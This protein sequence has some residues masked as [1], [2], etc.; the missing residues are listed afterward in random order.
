MV[1]SGSG[2]TKI[3]AGA[4]DALWHPLASVTITVKVSEEVTVMPGVFSPSDHKYDDAVPVAKV[5]APPSQ[6][7]VG[8]SALITGKGGKAF[9]VTWMG[10]DGALW[11]PLELKTR[12]V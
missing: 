2:L 8:P 11:H 10:T 12:T 9:T 4:E 1:T 3:C 6:N 7:V 5:T